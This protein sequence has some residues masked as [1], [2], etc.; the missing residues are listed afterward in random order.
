MIQR[1]DGFVL[2]RFE[3]LSH[4]LQRSFGTTAISCERASLMMATAFMLRLV[5]A[6]TG[7]SRWLDVICVLTILVQFLGTYLRADDAETR[8]LRGTANPEKLNY[9]WRLFLLIPGVLFFPLDLQRGAP[10][11]QFGIAAHYFRACDDLPPGISRVRK[12]LNDI[13]AFFG[14]PVILD[15][16]EFAQQVHGAHFKERIE[17]YAELLTNMGPTPMAALARLLKAD[18]DKL[19]DGDQLLLTAAAVELVITEASR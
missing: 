6:E 13:G 7:V 15:H 4:F 9:P 12:F 19:S 16:H 11:L 1:I 8:A 17:P 10:W 5:I 2:R 3:S 18:G 14:S